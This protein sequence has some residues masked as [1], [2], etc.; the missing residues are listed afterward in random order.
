MRD[1]SIVQVGT[2]EE[3]YFAPVDGGRP[4]SSARG[5]SSPARPHRGVAHTPLGAVAT[6]GAAGAVALLVR[7][8]L[9]G[10][11]PDPD[12][13][14]EVVSREF[15]VPRRLLTVVR[16]NGLELVSQRPSN[17][18]GSRSALGSR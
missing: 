1:G 11:A 4:S 6:N 2:P 15:R 14:G 5:T 10:L 16:V 9:V 13:D 7:P 3:L 17:E 18:V 8:E 12:G